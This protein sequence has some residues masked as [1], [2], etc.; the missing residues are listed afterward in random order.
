MRW[1]YWIRKLL[2]TYFVPR[3]SF[4]CTTTAMLDEE[5]A[6]N[7]FEEFLGRLEKT[8]FEEQFT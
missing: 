1:T 4:A 2:G 7:V 6:L 5:N 8:A 3:C